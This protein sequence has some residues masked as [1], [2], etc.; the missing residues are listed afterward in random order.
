[1]KFHHQEVGLPVDVSVNWTTCPGAGEPGLWA[2][3]EAR[4]GADVA[5]EMARVRLP[6]SEPERVLVTKVTVYNP[7]AR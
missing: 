6:L 5:A 1:L 3:E 7:A 2:K 4:V